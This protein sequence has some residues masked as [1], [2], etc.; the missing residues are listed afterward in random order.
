MLIA[1][2]L[3]FLVKMHMLDGA[4]SHSIVSRGD[5]QAI[6]M[7]KFIFSFVSYN[8]YEGILLYHSFL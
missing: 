2:F 7:S 1:I 8:I 4:L 3:I 5:S 6:K